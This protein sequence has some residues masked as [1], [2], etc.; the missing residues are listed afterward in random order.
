MLVLSWLK[1]LVNLSGEKYI[2]IGTCDAQIPVNLLPTFP[3]PGLLEHLLPF[4]LALPST[5]WR[6]PDRITYHM[7]SIA[8]T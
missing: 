8:A 2:W 1:V 6:K 4:T 5:V 3:K 7:S